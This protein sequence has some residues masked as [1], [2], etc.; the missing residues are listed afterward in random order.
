MSGQIEPAEFS[1]E[2]V[3]AFQQFGAY[4]NY[5]SHPDVRDGLKLGARRTVWA[6]YELTKAYPEKDTIKAASV[7]G[8]VMKFHPHGDSGIYDGMVTMAHVPDDGRPVKRVMPLIEGQGSWGNYDDGAAASRYTECKLAPAAMAMLGDTRGMRGITGAPETRENAVDMVD[9]YDGRQKEPTILPALLPAY[10]INGNEGIG[11]GSST[12]SPGHNITEVMNLA[13]KMVDTPNPR[14][15]TIAQYLPGPDMPSDADIFDTDDGGIKAYMTEGMGGFVMRARY[16]VEEY[17]DGRKTLHRMVVTGLP[18][19]VTPTKVIG[20]IGS[21]VANGEIA[22]DLEAHDYSANGETEVVIDLKQNPV[23]ETIQ[24]LLFAGKTTG[25]QRTF[26]VYSNAIVDGR[27]RTIGTIE[28]LRIW[29]EHRREV[30]TRRSRYRLDRAQE[31]MEIVLGFIKA[32]PIGEEIVTLVRASNDK[33]DAADGMIAKWGFTDR[34][35]YAVLDMSLSQLTKLSTDRY[36][37][38][39]ESLLEII[40]DCEDL[41]AHPASLD[42]RLKQE[43]R[44]V[45]DEFGEDRRGTLRLGESPVIARPTTPAI[46]VPAAKGLFVLGSSGWLRWAKTRGVNREMGNDWVTSIKPI[47]NQNKL[48]AVSNFGYQ[49]RLLCDDLPEKMTKVDALFP[50]DPGEKIVYTEVGATIPGTADLVMVSDKG[51][52]KRLNEDTWTGITPKEGKPVFKNAIP[53][54]EDDRVRFAFHLPEGS[55]I[56]ILTSW[57]RLTRIKEEAI[58]ARGRGA[59]GLGTIRFEGD[60]DEIVWAGPITDDTQMV[61]WTSEEQIGWFG[62]SGLKRVNRTSLGQTVTRSNNRIIGA[63][64][65]EGDT[66]N[67]FG[68]ESGGPQQVRLEGQT[69]GWNLSDRQL[70]LSADGI[71]RARATWITNEAADAAEEAA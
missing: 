46:E 11:V 22:G 38:E 44:A 53:T 31:R 65:G 68:G 32:V 18:Y 9:N 48:D 47:T 12:L 59:A 57:G 28:A 30:V 71:K 13:I 36:E 4:A 35:A 15:D 43:M 66:F 24:R 25:L 52:V 62:C 42:K 16:T 49:Y 56:G 67:Y 14:W 17:K 20:G 70:K 26:S 6:M 10:V 61:Y 54:E 34:Q 2:A 21:M 55:D 41:L 63:A 40:D 1:E 64:I 5:R 69:A 37:R 39:R 33:S 45:R 29:I 60:T 58:R 8:D 23:D 27:V 19:R 7:T 51:N 3:S 50:L